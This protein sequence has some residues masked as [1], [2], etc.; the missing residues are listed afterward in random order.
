M[1]TVGHHFTELGGLEAGEG[2][3][4]VRGKFVDYEDLALF[5]C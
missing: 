3:V 2:E 1:V 5:A 4:A